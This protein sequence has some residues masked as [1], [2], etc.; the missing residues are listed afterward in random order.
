MEKNKK[1]KKKIIIIILSVI[2]VLIVALITTY[3]ISLTPVSKKYETVTFTVKKGEDKETIVGNLKEA[4]LIKS[5]YATLIH[6]IL[7]GNKNIQAGSYEFSRSMSAKDIIKSLN[8]GEIIDTKKPSARITFPEGLTLKQMITLLASK[9]DLKLDESLKKVNEKAFLEQLVKDYWFLT[10]DILDEN[11]YYA[12]EGYLFPSTY[13]FYLDTTVENAIKKM[14]NET[15]K[16]LDPIKKEIED[17][18]YS[19][20]EIL[21]MASIA[22]KEANSVSDRESVAQ[23]IYKRLE[24]KMSLGMDV[25]AFYG[26]GKEMTDKITSADLNDDNPYNTRL[27]TFLGLPAGPICNPSIES[28]KA[29]LNPSKT[30]YIY[31]FADKKG[32]VHFTDKKSE[33]DEFKK[34]YG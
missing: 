15:K 11:I 18:G 1:N 22:E 28:I 24:L 30:N 8:N 7:N 5:K 27:V 21:T 4:N 9:T 20:H 2:A 14:L 23:V 3:F 33:F 16:K 32:V 10:N 26:V 12:L 17:S 13:D 29:V 31:F 19:V 25:T 6:I 34:I